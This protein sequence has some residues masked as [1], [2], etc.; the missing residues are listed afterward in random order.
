MFDAIAARYDPLNTVLS[1]GIDRYWRWRRC[2]AR[3]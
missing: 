3:R 1:G 2:A